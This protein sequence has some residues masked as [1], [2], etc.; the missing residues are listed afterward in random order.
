MA[1]HDDT[2]ACIVL[3][4]SV[5]LAVVFNEKHAEWAE[6]NLAANAN[7]LKMSVVTLFEALIVVRK[8][9]PHLLREFATRLLT[10][11]GIEFV[12][13]T[14]EMSI[15]ASALHEQYPLN[16]GDCFVLALAQQYKCPIMT[17]DS[18]FKK[19]GHEIIMP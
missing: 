16:F 13:V 17:L 11:H 18:D 9:Q 1:R 8:R 14:L 4:T 10:T 3:D 15:F 7:N 12:P 2:S 5:L 19:T 6:I